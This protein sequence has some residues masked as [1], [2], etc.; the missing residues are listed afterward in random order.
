MGSNHWCEALGI[1]PPNLGAVKDHREA[2]TFARMLV[3][4]MERGAAMTLVEVADR[5]AEVGVAESTAALRSLQSC[6]PGRR[7]VHR[8]GDH[9][10]LD[11][12]DDELDLWV[13]MLGLRLPSTPPVQSVVFEPSPVLGDDVPL[14]VG[15]LDKAFTDQ[16]LEAWSARRLVLAVL[17]AHGQEPVSPQLAMEFVCQRTT[18]HLLSEDSAKFRRKNSPIVVAED[19]CWGLA[20]DS[21]RA[22]LVDEAMRTTRAAVR[23]KVASIELLGA[24]YPTLLQYQEADRERRQRRE[25]SAREH[26]LLSRALVVAFPAKQPS[27]VALLDVGNRTVE[28]F[29]LTENAELPE[30]RRR[31]ESYDIVG[32][33]DVRPLLQS[34]GF[35]TES[36][37]MSELGPPQKTI[38]VDDWGRTLRL[39]TTLLV[40]GSCR[41]RKPFG[42]PKKMQVDLV[43]GAMTKLRQ[44]LESDAKSLYAYY[45]Y[46]RLH[47]GVRVRSGRLDEFIP[48]SWA[49]RDETWL[50]DQKIT[51]LES[52]RC[53]EVVVGP[54]P[55]WLDP[56][57]GSRRVQVERGQHGP[58]A[59]WP[60]DGGKAIVDHDIQKARVVS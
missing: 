30:L 2:N 15:E 37:R 34:L 54:A 38:T 25:A 28:T 47:R 42:D 26:A 49:H 7:P 45:E 48:A 21:G 44:R 23:A 8:D 12:H 52:G 1:E 35:A 22:Q 17:D 53:M 33:Q 60:V 59:L 40:R 19:G 9:Y 56:W 18:W 31:I 36:M 27:I 32:A 24:K 29:V 13:F 50:N 5:F 57:A 55:D 11:P 6:K 4:L 10:W 58:G 20:T 16:N 41:I 14:S 51:A 39:T 46:G 43:K 3:A